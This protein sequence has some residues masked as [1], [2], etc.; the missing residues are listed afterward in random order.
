MTDVMKNSHSKESI[1]CFMQC[2]SRAVIDREVIVLQNCTN[3]VEVVPG[4]YSETR[5]TSDSANQ[6]MNIKG[7]E[8]SDVEEDPEPVTCLKI[9]A[10]PEV[11]YMS[12]CVSLI[13]RY[14]ICAEMPIFF[15][16]SVS[17]S[18]DMKQFQFVDC[19]LKS[20]F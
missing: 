5:T 20:V 4:P 15:L 13:G 3:L 9:K 14:H 16:N 6:A 18:V 8:V 1:R 7:E 11:R 17:L 12:V 19:M 2:G 10:E